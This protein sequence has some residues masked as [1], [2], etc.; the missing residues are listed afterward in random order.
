MR[1]HPTAGLVLRRLGHGA[2]VL[3]AAFTLAFLVLYVLPGDP[4]AILLG[5]DQSTATPEEIAAVRAEYNLDRPLFVQ[6]L[7]ALTSALRFDLGNSFATGQPVL[8]AIGAALP[9]TVALAF[10]ALVPALVGGTLLA[11]LAVNARRPALRALLSGLPGLG[12]ALPTFWVGLML[13]QVFSFRLGWVPALGAEGLLG[14]VLP[15]ATLALPLGAMVAQVLLRALDRAWREQYVTTFRAAGMGRSRLL[16]S[17]ALRVASLSLLSVAGV[18]TGNLL[19]GT[20]IVETVFTRSGLGRLAES[21]V[22]SQDIPLVLGIV[23]FSAVVFVLVN[24]ATDLL[25]PLADPRTRPAVRTAAQRA[26][27]APRPQ[28]PV[29]SP[30]TE[31][32]RA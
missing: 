4:V 6:Y 31:E 3:W 2:A 1:L 12:V 28:H 17:H 18:I 27:E 5:G 24:L 29:P 26:P 30:P 14:L 8:E 32:V 9:S 21:A 16:L 11:V 19:G 25:Y 22:S 13:L 20:V 10:A 23:V 15:A 7:L